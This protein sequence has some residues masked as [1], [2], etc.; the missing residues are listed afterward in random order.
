MEAFFSLLAQAVDWTTE[1]LEVLM[2]TYEEV[3]WLKNDNPYD[4]NI[5]TKYFPLHSSWIYIFLFV[6]VDAWVGVGLM[7]NRVK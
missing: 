3:S 5:N 2:V 6:K 1:Q 4:S 7:G